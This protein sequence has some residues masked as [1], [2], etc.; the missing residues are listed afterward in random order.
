MDKNLSFS[1]QVLITGVLVTLA[2]GFVGG[3]YY[4][5]AGQSSTIA[6][7]GSEAPADL[8]A[9]FVPFWTAWQTLETKY[10][11]S[12]TKPEPQA[13]VWGAIEGL[14]ESFGDPYTVFMPPA[15][16]EEFESEISGNFEGVGMEVGQRDGTLT[17]VAPLKDSP[18]QRAGV[19]AG[20][21]ILAIDGK[22][23]AD[24]PVDAAVKLIRGKGGTTV[25]LS[26]YREGSKQPL[27]VP[28]VRAVIQTPTIDTELRSDGVFVIRLYNFFATSDR[29]FRQALREFLEA[30]TDKLVIDLRGNPGGYLE[31]AVEMASWFLPLGKT[32]VTEDYGGNE[33]TKV[34]RSKGYDAFNDNLKMAVIVDGGSASASEILAGALSEHGKAKLFGVKTFGKGSVQE[35]VKITPDTSLKVTVARWLTPKGNSIS[36]G[37]LTPDFEVKFSSED[38]TAGKDPQLARAVTYLLSGK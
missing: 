4:S 32:I 24:L 7:A 35:L 18:A 22:P 13:R 14:T 11:G 27:E 1:R 28:I 5:R 29:L 26:L 19:K 16:A 20:D 8:S 21:K 3:N 2:V 17:V 12:K 10:V 6:V 25:T 23:A 36:E 38:Q 30:E 15:E 31:S 33:A 34:H 37:G 9:D